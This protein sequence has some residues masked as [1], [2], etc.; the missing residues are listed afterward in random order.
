MCT[1]VISSVCSASTIQAAAAK[2]APVSTAHSYSHALCHHHALI[3]ALVTHA[4][5]FHDNR[6]RS[7]DCGVCCC[8]CPRNRAQEKARRTALFC[9]HVCAHCLLTSPRC[10]ARLVHGCTVGFVCS[11]PSISLLV[12]P[13]PLVL[14]SPT[15]PSRTKLSATG[16]TVRCCAC[17]HVCMRPQVVCAC[18]SQSCGRGAASHEVWRPHKKPGGWQ[19]R[20]GK[21]ISYQ[22][23]SG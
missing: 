20:L 4:Q 17:V 12:W 19:G 5:P 21:S 7:F 18:L 22:S 3:V 11:S 16:T 23:K 14:L 13:P 2:R 10:C 9:S 8:R 1:C 15:R 6:M